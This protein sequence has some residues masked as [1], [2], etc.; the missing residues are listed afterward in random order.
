MFD[1]AIAV[2]IVLVL[3]ALVLFVS[4]RA[5]LLIDRRMLVWVGVVFAVALAVRLVGLGDAGQTWDEDVNWSAG[6]NYITNLLSLDFSEASWVWNYQHPPVMKYVAGIGAQFADG[7]GVARL[8]SALLVAFACGLLVPIGRRLYSIRVGVLAGGFAA[9]TPHL[10]AHS[11]VVGHEAP[12]VLLWT[13]AILL[14]LSAHDGNAE[15]DRWRLHRR[16]AVI[17]I[18]LGLAIFQRFVNGLLAPLIGMILLVNSSKEERVQTVVLGLAIIPTVALVTGFAVWPR[19]WQ[20]PIAH[21][22]EAWAV[23]K[24]THSPEPFLGAITNEPPSSYFAIYLYAT[25]PIGLL[26]GAALWLGRSIVERKRAAL[27]VLAWLV[28]PLG[29]MLSPVRQDGV[30]YVMPVVIGLSF[31]AA[32][33][34]EWGIGAAT[35]RLG[36]HMSGRA[37]YGLSIALCVYLLATCVRIHPYYLDYYGEQVGG[38]ERVA[39]TKSFEVAWWGE[40]LEP[41]MAYI[42]ENAGPDDR[43]FKRCVEP[44]HLTWMRGDLWAREAANPAGADWFLIYAP[45]WKKCPIPGDAQMVFDVTVSGAPLARVYRR[46]H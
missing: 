10:I 4:R 9:L 1:G 39:A 17:G 8:L 38:V 14:S 2:A 33:G 25:A 13:V 7:Y 30:R 22:E 5:L 46:A 37:F 43:V 28:V 40:G 3:V 41:A 16:F 12:T 20:S 29:V 23:L 18:V 21:M 11:K 26:V 15:Q 6:R 27:I 24:K 19:L 44:S 32:A 36:D 34:F 35:R 45:S 42:N 31:A